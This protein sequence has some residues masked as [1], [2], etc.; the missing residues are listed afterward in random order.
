[1][2]LLFE[3]RMCLGSLPLG[4]QN[5]NTTWTITPRQAR[6]ASETPFTRTSKRMHCSRRPD[7]KNCV[8]SLVLRVELE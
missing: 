2:W 5:N 1:M 7:R 3:N 8:L 4:N 6:A